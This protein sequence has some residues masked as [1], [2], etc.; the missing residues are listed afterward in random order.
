MSSEM[1][2]IWAPLFI[3]GIYAYGIKSAVKVFLNF[4]WFVVF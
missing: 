1:G 2:K 3:L 4:S